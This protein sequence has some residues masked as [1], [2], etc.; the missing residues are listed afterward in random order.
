MNT[1]KLIVDA[2]DLKKSETV[3]PEKKLGEISD[4]VYSIIGQQS[5]SDCC[6]EGSD[7]QGFDIFF[8][9]TCY[10]SYFCATNIIN[11]EDKCLEILERACINALKKNNYRIENLKRT[12]RISFWN[13]CNNYCKNAG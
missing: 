8:R 5:H 13:L 2:L 9:E 7:R 10:N 12:F 6:S 11:D 1:R 3:F 4:H